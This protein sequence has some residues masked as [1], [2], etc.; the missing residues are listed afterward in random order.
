MAVFDDYTNV[1]ERRKAENRR[2]L[3]NKIITAI[4]VS[5]AVLLFV[6]VAAFAVVNFSHPH[7][8]S[9]QGADSVSELSESN[10]MITSVCSVVQY[11]SACVTSVKNSIGADGSSG[12]AK[13]KEV[14]KAV[15]KAAVD[16]QQEAAKL[17]ETLK[18]GDEM[19]KTALSDCKELMLYA[20]DDLRSTLSTV[21]GHDAST[22]SHITADLRNWLSGVLSYQ[23]TCLDGL[24]DGDLKTRMQHG[25][26]NATQLT[27]NALAIV[28]QFSSILS[29][30]QIPEA[31]AKEIGGHR[32]LMSDG[33][34][35]S[36]LDDVDDND[37]FP[38]WMPSS[39]RRLLKAAET[40]IPADAVVAKDGSGNYTTIGAALAG[41]PKKRSGR[42]VIFVKAGVYDEMV[43]VEKD[44]V[45][46][47][48]YGD[49]SRKTI[50]TG[51]KNFIDGT[52]TFR[53]A[54]FVAIGDGFIARS[55][56]FSNTAGAAKHQ[57]VALRV[58][59]D[60]SSFLNCR[61]DGYQDTLYAQTHRQFYRSCVITGTIDFIFGDAAAIFQNCM[62]VIR[63]PLPNQQN[64]ITAHGRTDKNEPTGIVIQNCKILADKK[65]L[66]DRLK[67]PSYLGRPWKQYS[68]TVV[69]ESIIG[70]LIRPEGWLPWDGDFALDTLFYAEFNNR[71]PGAAVDKRIN[72]KGFKVIKDR[73]EALKFTAE[74][75]IDGAS[76]IK[77]TGSPVRL[78]LFD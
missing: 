57:A 6:A 9:K 24:K 43:T 27:S 36:F 75:F 78:S 52:P 21:T 37:D 19:H 55:I 51:S 44:M 10:K 42:Y 68:R 26:A 34:G 74:K 3:I 4:S 77:A 30:L 5:V 15:I 23:D 11:P 63:K 48:M 56:G 49:G 14:V 41:M 58:Q 60:R 59:S 54:T 72:W 65:L 8:L 33:D 73:A 16:E 47:T 7:A 61:M 40:K 28:T 66:Q 35:D 12:A 32:R 13:P 39:D 22:L 53:T 64:T 46:V 45:N 17:L 25:L 18:A 29:Q 70:D 50:I 1:A 67:I 38:E 76:W 20:V 2:R 69:M 62:I 71:G 31:I